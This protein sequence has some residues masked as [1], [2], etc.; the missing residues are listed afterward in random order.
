MPKF[1]KFNSVLTP[2]TGLHVI[3]SHVT[4][5]INCIPRGPTPEYYQSKQNKK[6]YMVSTLFEKVNLPVPNLGSTKSSAITGIHSLRNGCHSLRPTNFLYRS[7]SPLTATATSPKIVSGRV[8][9][10]MIS[11]SS[12]ND[13]ND[14]SCTDMETAIN[15]LYNTSFNTSR[16]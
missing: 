6:F 13:R 3:T 16:N 10:T 9:A 11:S 8:V 12:V 1:F 4:T 14:N 5:I 7:S 2:T 15:V